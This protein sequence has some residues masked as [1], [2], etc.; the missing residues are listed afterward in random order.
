MQVGHR[1]LKIYQ[2]A[3]ELAVEIHKMSMNL[4]RFEMYEEGSQIR[5]SSKSVPANIVEGYALRKYKAEY[6]H[7]LYRAYASSEETIE[8]LELLQETGSL[9]DGRLFSALKGKYDEMNKMI[10]CFIRAVEKEH[11]SPLYLK[12]EADNPEFIN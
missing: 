4:P 12:E 2:A 1:Q 10:F 9:S 3:H 11:G 5:R 8:H 6:L 7:Y